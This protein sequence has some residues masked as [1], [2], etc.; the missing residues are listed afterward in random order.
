MHSVEL[1]NLV[2]HGHSNRLRSLMSE[3]SAEQ[4]LIANANSEV[5]IGGDVGRSNCALE[6]VEGGFRLEKQALAIS[7]GEHADLIAA[8]ARRDPES[9]PT[10]QVQALCRRSSL[11]LERT[12]EWDAIGLR[13]TC[14]NGFLL[15]AEVQ[16]DM[17]YPVSF[18]TMASDGGI[19]A[20][21]ILLSAV[22]V[23]LAE[24]AAT[25]AHGY[26]RAA[27]RRNVGT[28]PPSALRLAELSVELQQAR[29]M[30]TAASSDFQKL[31]TAGGLDSPAFLAEV[32]NLKV[33]TSELAARIATQALA[34]C[35]IAGYKRDTPFCLDRQIRDAH[36]ALVMVS[37]DRYLHANAE[38]L[39]ARKRL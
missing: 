34:I 24:S 6:P 31:A 19:Q 7:Y 16:A 10:D 38:M 27:A 32:R 23:G 28:V 8:T 12:S 5:G 9:E 36:G 25:T 22:W 30:L 4:L 20:S 2:R 29:N 18:G 17:V 15:K 37:N 3:I 26:V 14:S 11:E 35:G 33:A 39:L 1:S 21:T 13:G